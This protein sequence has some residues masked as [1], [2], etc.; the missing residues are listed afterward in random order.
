MNELKIE[1]KI[2]F[3]P[4]FPYGLCSRQATT[5][6]G[7]T[8]IFCSQ[9]LLGDDPDGLQKKCVAY[10]A[11]VTK[12]IKYACKQGLAKDTTFDC[13]SPATEH[14]FRMLTKRGLQAIIEASDEATADIEDNECPEEETE[15][16]GK[17]KE[18][19]HGKV[20]RRTEDLRAELHEYAS[21]QDPEDQTTF[22]DLLFDSVLTGQAT[23]LTAGLA[24]LPNAK[25]S[26]SKYSPFQL[27]NIWRHSHITAMF[28]TNNHLTYLDRR[29]YDTGFAIDGIQDEE[30]YHAYLEKYGC[31]MA[32][33]TYRAL[34]DWYSQN[35]GYYRITQRNPD[36]SD[37]AYDEWLDTPAFYSTRELPNV[38]DKEE[39]H[40]DEAAKGSQQRLFNI[41]VGIATGRKIN[42]MC[43]HAKPGPFK[44][45]KLREVQTRDRAAS[46]V[47]EM[48]TQCPQMRCADTVEYGLYF[49]SSYHQFLALFERTK[50]KFIK[51]KT[52]KHPMSDPYASMH[53]IPVNDA[54]TVLLWC[55]L[56]EGPLSAQY[57]ICN[58][59][60]ERNI[61]FKHQVDPIFPLLFRGRKVF[62]GYTMNIA[63][64][65]TAL[66]CYLEGQDFYLC[67]FAEQ[68]KW[69]SMLFPG[70][71]IL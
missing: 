7:L 61:G 5:I 6:E 43:Y 68:A 27:Y 54:G 56:E 60:V 17:I 23:P 50:S 64:I 9:I 30:S 8:N 25:I 36:T 44:W 15:N 41:T 11:H 33:F 20:S 18:T 52:T 35:P 21:S 16:D 10:K 13:G 70:I 58:N 65:H 34:T 63:A 49:C 69:Y 71:T 46:I 45:N 59:L 32:A 4:Y 1:Q 67:C 14:S 55:L 38:D 42:F 19:I 2:R 12:R 53:A 39:G 62:A 28:M 24:N 66:E 47:R 37:E 31:T 3:L 51:G 26:T 48:K 57:N 22:R 40:Y 29:P